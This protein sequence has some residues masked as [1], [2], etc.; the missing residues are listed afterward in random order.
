MNIIT[1]EFFKYIGVL[2]T[3]IQGASFRPQWRNLF[4]SAL[5]VV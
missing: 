2:M 3:D 1:V 5:S 4:T